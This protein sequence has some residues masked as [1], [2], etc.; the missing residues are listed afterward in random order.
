MEILRYDD[1]VPR[2]W[3]NG[4][5]ITREIAT[6]E[7]NG[8]PVF[9]ISRADVAQDGAFSDFAGLVRILTVVSESG[10]RLDH[11][12]GTMHARPWHPVRFD[13]A[14]PVFAR[15]E[16]DGLTDLNLI[17]DARHCQG[18][19]TTLQ[20]TGIHKLAV[21]NPGLI[22]LH[23]LAGRAQIGSETIAPG[24]TLFLEHGSHQLALNPGDAMLAIEFRFDAQSESIKLRIA[25]P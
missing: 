19:V 14:L 2:P 20:Q 6:G 23:G 13:G 25:R 16:A 21:A 24:D 4:G 1:L 7:L 11:A 8:T 5:G 18:D 22:A 3:K 12:T 15:L 10:M 17:F 9:R